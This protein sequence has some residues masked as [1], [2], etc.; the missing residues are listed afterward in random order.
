MRFTLLSIVFSGFVLFFTQ[1]AS[2]QV[3]DEWRNL[4]TVT[5]GKGV[6]HDVVQVEKGGDNIKKLK[7]K[8]AK[9]GV[10]ID[11]IVVNYDGMGREELEVREDI[12]NGGESRVIDLRGSNKDIKTIELY[13]NDKGLVNGKAEITV[14]GKN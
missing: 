5:A 3:R 14:V 13:Y 12:R 2:A 9:S 6:D 10:N 1:S 7:I 8:V 11:H 4:G